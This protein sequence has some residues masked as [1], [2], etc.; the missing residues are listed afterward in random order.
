MSGD[1]LRQVSAV[2]T[3]VQTLGLTSSMSRLWQLLRGFDQSLSVASTAGREWSLMREFT[4]GISTTFNGNRILT[5]LRGLSQAIST[6]F[7]AERM[8]AAIRT[9]SQ[10]ITHTFNTERL[11]ALT[12]TVSAFITFQRENLQQNPS[13]EDPWYLVNEQDE[14]HTIYRPDKWTVSYSYGNSDKLLALEENI[15][16]R[17]QGSAI[18]LEYLMIGE[19]FTGSLSVNNG[20]NRIDIDEDQYLEGGGFQYAI[21]GLS[22]YEDQTFMFYDNESQYLCRRWAQSGISEDVGNGWKIVSFVWKPSYLDPNE[23]TD[24]GHIP[25]IPVGATTAYFVQYFV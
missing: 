19:D 2:R 14:N 17:K 18:R 23:P 10:G 11:W 12:R 6:T 7:N 3:P 1:A 15:I 21:K 9:A 4:Q 13:L 20:G 5:A 16:V 8:L 25:Y 24:G 22:V